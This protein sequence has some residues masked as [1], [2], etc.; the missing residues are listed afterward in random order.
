METVVPE[1]NRFV[2]AEKPWDLNKASKAGDASA[3]DRLGNVL[4]DLVEAC[5]VVGLAIA[6]FMP[7][8]SP[9][10]LAQL[11]YNFP[12]RADGNGGPPILDELRWEGRGAESGKVGTAEP[13]FP[14]LDVD[15][16]DA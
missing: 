5:R 14:R 7:N 2:D 12:Y 10:V 13:L 1:A 3:S 16:G 8:T 15:S 4:G 11:G 9:R 6:P